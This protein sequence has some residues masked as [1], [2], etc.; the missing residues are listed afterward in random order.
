MALHTEC[1]AH[2]LKSLREPLLIASRSGRILEANVAGAEALSTGVE[3]LVGASLADFSPT[4]A[5][6]LTTERAFPIRSRDGR[7]F[8]CDATVLAPDTLLLR[9]SGGSD[10]AR[11]LRD[12][13]SSLD[14][15]SA[16]ASPTETARALLALGTSAVGAL[17]AGVHLLDHAGH[18]LELVATVNSAD[19]NV[20]RFRLIPMSAPLPL[21]E[22]VKTRSP[23]L[24]GTAEELSSRFPDFTRAHPELVVGAIACIPLEADGACIGV[25]AMRF[26]LPWIF[27]EQRRARL[28][29]L[30][31]HCARA[32]D[33]SKHADR[34]PALAKEALARLELLNAFS[35]ALAKAI[36]P[37]DVVETIVEMA[38]AATSARSG[39]LWLLSPDGGTACLA[40]GSGPT[41]PRAE[42]YAGVPLDQ[43][44]R[45]PILDAM[46]DG[47]AVWIESCQQLEEQ[48]PLAFRAFS[49]KG[50]G[51]SS[52]ACLPLFGQGRCI[53]GLALNYAGKRRFL[54]DERA[55][56]KVLA[57]HSAQAVER[58]RLYAAERRAKEQAEASHRRSAFLARASAILTSTL[59][60]SDTLA[61]IAQAAVPS[62]AH[63]CIV[64]LRDDEQNAPQR[65]AAHMDPEKVPFVLDLSRRFREADDKDLYGILAVIRTGES[66]F[67]PSFTTDHVPPALAELLAYSEVISSLVVPIS[68]RGRTLGAILLNRVKP[69]P[70]YDEQDLETAEDLGRRVGLALDNARLFRDAREADRLKDDFLAMLSHELR[71]PLTPI[72]TAIDIMN[73]R[74]DGSFARERAM[75]S[76][77]VGHLVRLVDDLL[78]VSRVTRGKFRLEKVRCETSDVIAEAVEMARPLVEQRSHHL[79][80]SAPERGLPIMADPV[81]LAQAVANLLINAAKYTD[82]GGNIAVGASADESE[83]VVSVRDSGRGIAPEV[84]PKVFDLFVQGEP[85]SI[86]RAQGGLGIG[87]TVVKGIVELHGGRVSVKSEGLG[88]GS[89]FVIRLPLASAEAETSRTLQ[90]PAPPAPTAKLRILVVDDNPDAA[91]MLGVA[92]ELL[93]CSVKLV[94]DAAS[95]LAVI[96][97]FSPDC[98]LMDIGLPDID[99]YELARR[100]R[101]SKATTARLIAVTGYG[102]DSDVHRAL[103]AGFDDHLLKPVEIETLEDVLSS[104]S[105]R[106]N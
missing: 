92:L 15:I 93:G 1:F 79:T 73:R 37:P 27:D 3:E 100:I 33:P 12:E 32:F 43:P 106:P 30:G 105:E 21:I 68:A 71:N 28:L 102:Q 85:A 64:E 23:V 39:G 47:K 104:L 97:D 60:Y 4:Q 80:I 88:R 91:T 9:L 55:F 90:K 74:D 76:R 40:R 65:I 59:D 75:V 42:A 5:L 56:L 50:A 31:S 96:A 53:G 19:S 51:E 16:P 78:D 14:G 67:Y 20:D 10:R 13:L 7:R 61:A 46:R 77:H 81:R 24:L 36:T 83:C 95:A 6:A 66:K 22:A 57:Q 49:Q 11:V 25:L 34:A 44:M 82:R 58:A 29:E 86:D 94:H 48:Y 2:V 89:E 99:G 98:V 63:S 52:L 17:T 72:R 45:M 41:G 54:E 38:M 69:G 8:M 70:P 101:Q 62:F 35:G 18:N 84:L 26:P 87:L 103:E